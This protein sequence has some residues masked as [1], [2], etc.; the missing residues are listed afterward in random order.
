[1]SLRVFG[2]CLCL[3]VLESLTVRPRVVIQIV[4]QLW[5]QKIKNEKIIFCQIG[6]CYFFFFSIYL[7]IYQLSLFAIAFVN[8]KKI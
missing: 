1:M 7:F 8:E 2:I 4:K 5:L 6:Y 3:P